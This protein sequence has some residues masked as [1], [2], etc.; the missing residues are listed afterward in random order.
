[1]SYY[2]KKY[3]LKNKSF[4]NA[5]NYGL[6]SVSLPVYP[7]LKDEEVDYICKIINKF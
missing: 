5:V 7:K 2:K 4:K 1:M 6:S 3:K